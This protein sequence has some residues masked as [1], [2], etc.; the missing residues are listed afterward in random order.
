MKKEAVFKFEIVLY[1]DDTLEQNIIVVDGKLDLLQILN[2]HQIS[3][4]ALGDGFKEIVDKAIQQRIEDKK[5]EAEKQTNEP[6]LPKKTTPKKRVKRVQ[7]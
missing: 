1:D 6:I 2:L 4:K 7:K 3:A 5:K